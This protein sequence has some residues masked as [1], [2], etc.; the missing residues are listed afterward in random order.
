VATSKK[1][2]DLWE[3]S[4]Q[5]KDLMPWSSRGVTPGRVWIYA[6]DKA[7]LRERWRLFLGANGEERRALLGEARD[8]T[9][10][11][12]VAPLPGMT[13]YDTTP[14]RTEQREQPEPVEVGYRSFDRQ[15]I[16]PDHRLMVVGRPDLWAVRGPGQMFTVEQNAHAVVSGPALVFSDLIPDMHYFN[17]RSGCVRPLY[18]DGRGDMPNVAPGLLDL[19]SQRLSTAVIP[20]DFLAY[21]AAVASH[22]AYTLRFS[23][24][25]RTRAPASPS[26]STPTCGGK[27]SAS[28]AV[29]C[30]CTAT[31]RRTL[32]PQRAGQLDV[33]VSRRTV[34]NASSRSRTPLKACPRPCTTSRGSNVSGSVPAASRRCLGRRGSTRSPA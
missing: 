27:R 33:L 16:I 24:I 21:V 30:G 12:R 8:R 5:L 11:S 22:P 28:V 9:I 1:L 17:G 32:T 25:S 7:T 20:E 4:P 3:S 13:A 29:S 10:D 34:P 31:V 19:L 6:P 23:T 18:R 2:S 15:L 14:L 26:V